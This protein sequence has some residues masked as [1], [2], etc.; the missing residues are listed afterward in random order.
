MQGSTRQK[1]AFTV[2]H[3]IR[4]LY[5]RAGSGKSTRIAE[6]I[7]RELSDGRRV[8]L[9]V[10]EQEAV[11]A[12]R[13]VADCISAQKEQIPTVNLEILNFRRLANRVFRTFGGLSY[14]YIGEGARSLIMWQALVFAAPQLKEYGSAL[15]DMPRLI[16]LMLAAVK[17]CKTYR[18]LP[19][20][21]MEAAGQ[22]AG[23]KAS[24]SAKL[25]DLG[26]IYSTYE[27]LLK[28]EYDDPQDDL[29]RLD[30]LLSE[31]DAFGGYSIYIDSFHGFTPQE[32]A[33]IGH[34]F[35]Q[36]DRVTVALGMLPDSREM[37][38]DA[39]RDTDKTL[40]QLASGIRD[41]SVT[42]ICMTEQLCFQHD[43][44][45]RLEKEL[46]SFGG[47][48]TERSV[49]AGDAVSVVS[50][51]DVYAEAEYV[52]QSVLKKVRETGCR[53]RDIA[54]IMRNPE[55]YEG[56]MDAY[57]EKYEIPYFI[58][59]RDELREKPLIKL[60]LSALSVKSDGWRCDDVIAYLKT[61]LSG[62]SADD[63]DLL[64][65]YAYLWNISG[66]RW[67]EEYDW[68][69]HPRG[70]R[71]KLTEEDTK[72]LERIN[73]I[74][75]RVTEPLCAFFEAF[76]EGATV[77]SVSAALYGLLQ[78]LGIEALCGTEKREE[79]IRIWNCTIDALDQLVCVLPELPVTAEQYSKLFSMLIRSS[80]IGHI[81]P[82]SD[83]V[84]IGSAGLLRT[85]YI[86]H[87]FLVGANEGVFPATVS[88]GSIF[89]DTD[90]LL[91]ENLCE[92]TL[93]PDTDRLSAEELYRFYRSVSCASDSVTV[94]YP[95]MGLRGEALRPSMPVL[96]IRR[97]F[98]ELLPVQPE[99]LPPE[100][101]AQ[102]YA[103]SFEL[104]A[105]LR[106][107]AF[108]KALMRIY[109]QDM[110]FAGRIEAMLCPL[111]ERHVTIR[112]ETV[113]ELF[114]GDITLTQSR[115]ESFCGCAFSF[116]C[117]YYLKLDD[118]RQYS[119][120]PSD[121]GTFIHRMLE[122][123]MQLARQ[124]DGMKTDYTDS[125]ISDIL[126]GM[127]R[128]YLCGIFGAEF[129]RGVC[130]ARLVKTFG[131]MKRSCE[132]IVRNLLDEFSQSKFVP[133]YF[134]L[135]IAPSGKYPGEK[136]VPP[137]MIPTG[138]GKSV[139]V[140]GQIDRV[141][142]LNRGDDVY[143]RVV[144][145]KT[146]RKDFDPDD[147]KEGL[148]TQMFLY[149]FSLLEAKDRGFLKDIGV[150]NG[151]KVLPAGVLYC[152]ARTDPLSVS[153]EQ[154]RETVTEEVRRAIR[155]CG[156]LTNRLD[157]LRAMEADLGARYIPVSLKKDE[158]F[159]KRSAVIGT[160]DEFEYWERTITETVSEK[161]RGI[162]K[163][164]ADAAPLR[165]EHNPCGF[166]ALKP[167]CRGG[168]CAEGVL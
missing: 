167:V 86:R 153:A 80:D 115:L 63:C 120:S 164:C 44:L 127:I 109:M 22:V 14:R 37:I 13:R 30:T 124:E 91:L 139:C 136:T 141:D 99:L 151:G 33:V 72:E 121:S 77:R 71:D 148:N 159:T 31:H 122:S 163:G 138:D 92:M 75:R 3:D 7:I 111:A 66:R 40:R 104:A 52:A 88:E 16:D 29:T 108:G 21:L 116:W 47:A 125:E 89:S 128:K 70:Y 32:F 90:K 149:L 17:E 84:T 46:F 51:G 119:F 155:R 113:N 5:G 154:T 85:G 96:R 59:R 114:P 95:V 41:A 39:L 58:S 97:L 133:Q 24:L 10:P 48:D 49:S 11:M 42:G 82:A 145:Y 146:G 53:F 4:F 67:Y 9:L 103:A 126:D 36:A 166:C 110:Q 73:E 1:G 54:I 6:E 143:V 117:K 68:T 18:I 76:G 144:D 162:L 100:E 79:A 118:I 26:L 38:F 161:A 152:S 56:V 19:Q 158:T 64:E 61:G 34:M 160:D 60:I 105:A 123:F 131:R 147:L 134:E 168:I 98:P 165:G 93:S 62:I 150:K 23:E 132:Q 102:G 87:V 43:A 157:V 137:L 106:D 8:L 142:T 55:S 27:K 83:T 81:P 112:Q 15:S 140:C 45:R 35:R 20:R 94:S 12:E 69:M 129:D 74:R 107:S 135:K 78:R 50:S 25:H 156:L 130:S 2:K 28:Q 57:L 65:L 101:R